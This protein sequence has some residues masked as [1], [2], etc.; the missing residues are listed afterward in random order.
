MV[1]NKLEDSDFREAFIKLGKG[2]GS[3]SDVKFQNQF[4][5]TRPLFETKK[6]YFPYFGKIGYSGQIQVAAYN[7]L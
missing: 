5:D 2:R 7:A 1:D 4:F 3:V 6:K